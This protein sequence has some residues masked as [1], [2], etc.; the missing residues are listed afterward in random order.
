MSD[1]APFLCPA[2]FPVDPETKLCLQGDKGDKGATGGQGD[3]GDRGEQGMSHR[4]RYGIVVLFVLAA[5]ISVTGLAVGIKGIR[6]ADQ[7][8]ARV[9]HHNA[10]C[11]AFAD[12]AA[13]PPPAGNPASNPSRAYEQDQHAIFLQLHQQLGCG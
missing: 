7:A 9:S 8:N 6:L 4:V 1:K 2:G 12:L 5:I 10:L 13:V 3:K 11:H